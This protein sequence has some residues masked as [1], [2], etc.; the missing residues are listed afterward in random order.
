MSALFS[1]AFPI[2]KLQGCGNDFVF[3]LQKD[4]KLAETQMPEYAVAVCRKAF[5]VGAD[6]FV[7]LDAPAKD[8]AADIRWHFFNA[9]GSRAGMC[10]NG[11]RC[12]AKLAHALG[13]VPAK[14]VLATD[15]GDIA[16][17]VREDGLV[18]I[19]LTE[20]KG[21]KLSQTLKLLG[22]PYEV[23][24]VDTGVPHAVVFLDDLQGADVRALGR[25][26]RFHEAFAPAGTNANFAQVSGNAAAD[27]RTYERG[28]EDETYA[29]GT[30]ACATAVIAAS[31]GHTGQ[32]VA[33]TTSGGERLIV[34]QENGRVFL[35]GAATIVFTGEASKKALGL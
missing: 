4:L 1:D 6:G 29:C 30:G 32:E 31:L 21:L 18:K 35:T 22:Q 12:A 16:C 9:D 19:G 24:F 26:L 5:G 14:H 33:V 25:A 23:H 8:S 3:V 10:G 27:L 11:A 20:P 7:V 17:E 15:V 13:L 2:Y 34:N 28:V